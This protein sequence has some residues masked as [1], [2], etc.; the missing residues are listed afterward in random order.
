[1]TTLTGHLH[2]V[3]GRH[4]PYDGLLVEF[5]IRV[6][7]VIMMIITVF[8]MDNVIDHVKYTSK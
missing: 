3:N 5:N 4:G 8:I 1:M 2:A 7:I 6:M